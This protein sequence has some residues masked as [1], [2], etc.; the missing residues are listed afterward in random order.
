MPQRPI[1][2]W[3]R[4]V[5]ACFIAL[6]IIGNIWFVLRFSRKEAPFDLQIAVL[7]VL[8]LLVVSSLGMTVDAFL[9]RPKEEDDSSNV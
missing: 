2:H 8:V 5:A 3:K 6:I 4:A 9:K 7:I 1:T